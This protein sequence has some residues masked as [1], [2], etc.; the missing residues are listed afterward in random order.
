MTGNKRLFLLVIAL[1]L[2]LIPSPA[3][4]G[5]GVLI[6]CYHDVGKVDNDYTISTATLAAHFDFLRHNGYNPISLKQY[7][8][9]NATGAPLPDKPVLLTF[10][11]GY[12]SFYNEVFPLLKKYQFP[13]AL[14]VVTSWLEGRK[15]PDVGP[16]VNWQQIREMEASG[17]VAV[18]S[19]SH[20]LHHPVTANVFG[21]RGEAGAAL[22][23]HD[24]QYES[25]ESYRSRI[26]G[27]LAETQA[28]F[29]RELGHKAEVL[30]WPYGEYTL[31]GIE[32]GRRQGFK[33]FFTLGSGIN[34]VGSEKSLLEA[35][36]GMI[37]KNP[38]TAKLALFLKRQGDEDPPMRAAW[39]NI[40]RI[41]DPANPRQL[42][43]NVR[44]F[45]DRFNRLGINTVFIQA[46]SGAG[47][48]EAVYFHTGAVP[49]KAPV[50]DHIARRCR[51]EGI[52]VYAAMPTLATYGLAKSKEEAVTGA[53]DKERYPR[54]T[55]FSD[56]VRQTL[57]DMYSDLAT[58][59]FLDGVIFMDDAYLSDSEDFSPAAGQAFLA[60]FGQPLTPEALKDARTAAEW[61][62]IKTNLLTDMTLELSKAVLQF[63]PYAKFARTIYPEAL[64]DK[65]ARKN[66]AQD[67]QQ[68]LA[69]YDF[70]VIPA[71][72]FTVKG[73]PPTAQWASETAA[74]ALREPAGKEKLIF[75]LQTFDWEKKRWVSD[76]ELKETTKVLLDRGI[77]YFAFYPDTMFNEK[78]GLPEQ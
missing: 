53:G 31:P 66:Y 38:D 26:A 30:V 56:T 47:S 39:V 16:L 27:D 8:D 7:L 11:D 23:C 4:A 74:A 59:T 12:I 5:D 9:A 64:T 44:F 68:F 77:K 41:Y 63:R 65:N 14:A 69:S 22:I 71:T 67:Y 10:D 15:P 13:A 51:D 46:F 21:D 42:D 55:P 2:L 40:D 37:R 6:L 73:A 78:T 17:L 36:R 32:E 57:R 61:A 20:N 1:L 29:E 50:L 43:T 72:H 76:K 28:V 52:Y 75:L 48:V 45:I 62:R 34:P 18:A 60:N 35:R 25:L 54:A 24:G 58:Y 33:A 19:H 3:V 70:T 49:V